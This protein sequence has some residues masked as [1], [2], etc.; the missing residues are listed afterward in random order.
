MKVMTLLILTLGLLLN[1]S[2]GEYFLIET[3]GEEIEEEAGGDEGVKKTR[4]EKIGEDTDEVTGSL[5]DMLNKG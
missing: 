1:L 3:E 5:A 4:G 2:D